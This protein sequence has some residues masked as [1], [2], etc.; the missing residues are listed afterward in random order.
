MALSTCLCTIFHVY[1]RKDICFVLICCGALR[2]EREDVVIYTDRVAHCRH[3]GTMILESVL[4]NPLPCAKFP[5]SRRHEA[6]RLAR[7]ALHSLHQLH[8]AGLGHFNLE[9]AFSPSC[10]LAPATGAHPVPEVSDSGDPP[11]AVNAN[12]HSAL[13]PRTKNATIHQ[14]QTFK[15]SSPGCAA[16][17]PAAAAGAVAAQDTGARDFGGHID[18]GSP[19]H[20]AGQ[21]GGSADARKVAAPLHSEP[22][23]EN[24]P[25]A[26]AVVSA[27]APVH[28]THALSRSASCAL[29]C[30]GV[31]R[32]GFV[33]ANSDTTAQRGAQHTAGAANSDVLMAPKECTRVPETAVTGVRSRSNV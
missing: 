15:I 25:A 9:L 33:G 30:D 28:G 24:E 10:V 26:V 14:P 13:S 6:T 8:A 21:Q 12:T 27:G 29:E 31:L 5:C 4:S 16:M 7:L 11:D 18:S 2:G 3:E 23:H 20:S 32:K 22:P 1:A 17:P 19:S